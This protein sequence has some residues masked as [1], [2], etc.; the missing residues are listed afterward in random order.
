MKF[1][2][3]YLHIPKTAGTSF[4]M[5]AE[6][7]F[8]PDQVLNDYGKES[9]NTSDGIKSSVYD[10][11]DVAVLRKTGLQ[12]K[13]L[14]G[15]FCMV[16]YK[17]IF[18]DSPVVSFFREPVD[19]VIS[20]FVHFS[21]HYNFEG[22]LRDFYTKSQF[23][24]RQSHSMSGALPTDLDFY[25]LTEDYKKSL[26]LFNTKYG[27][28]F[29]M[30]KLNTGKYKGAAQSIASEDEL[31]EIRELNQKDIELYKYAVENF[32]K[33]STIESRSLKTMQ[34]FCGS[35]G[36]ISNGQVIGWTVDRE[37][38]VPAD[39][40]VTVNGEKRSEI[41]ANLYR[42]D[43]QR[44]G[45]HLDGNCGF[46][47]SLDKLGVIAPGDRISIRTKDGDYELTNSPVIVPS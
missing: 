31:V 19:R 12:H 23:Q 5:S 26:D 45:L 17:E 14:T 33:Q 34:R 46:H 39:L 20:E 9:P 6:Q 22:S 38:D 4:R 2:I 44:K 28:N 8:G 32:D 11:N 21:S 40:L 42:E 47:L 1:P 36:N 43:V 7:Y 13:F 15:H 16:K 29:P 30:A 41:V 37:S 25:G 3:I 35:V 10:T 18:P 27:T 24:N